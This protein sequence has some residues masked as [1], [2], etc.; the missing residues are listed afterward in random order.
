MEETRLLIAPVLVA[1]TG[2]STKVFDA[3]AYA[4]P[5]V[6]TT[7]GGYGFQPNQPGIEIISKET[8]VVF[9][10]AVSRLYGSQAAWQGAHDALVENGVHFTLTS[11]LINNHFLAFLRFQ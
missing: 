10:Q 4:I 6:T 8:P 3:F 7:E 2:I 5:V 9:A 11:W 1:G